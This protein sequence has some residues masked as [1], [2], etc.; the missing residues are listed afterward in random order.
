[1]QLPS[2]HPQPLL[3]TQLTRFTIVNQLLPC[4][5]HVV[6]QRILNVVQCLQ[7][8]RTFKQGLQMGWYNKPESNK[9]VV[10]YVQLSTQA[11]TC[12]K[13]LTAPSSAASTFRVT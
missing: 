12:V 10:C 1:M 13:G 3:P 5:C 6:M 7:D 4:P 9:Q 2:D 8:G 11:K